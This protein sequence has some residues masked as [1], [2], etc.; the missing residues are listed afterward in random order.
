MVKCHVQTFRQDLSVTR[1]KGQISAHMLCLWMGQGF[2]I[3]DR[4]GMYM[5]RSPG[6]VD[7]MV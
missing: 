7:G 5:L 1:D 6:C 2:K 3:K 4:G